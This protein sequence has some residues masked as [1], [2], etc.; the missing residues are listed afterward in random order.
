MCNIIRIITAVLIMVV[1]V[2][3]GMVEYILDT[4]TSSPINLEENLY[5]STT[6]CANTENETNDECHLRRVKKHLSRTT[7]LH[8]A[9][10]YLPFSIKRQAKYITT[11]IAFP[12]LTSRHLSALFCT[13]LI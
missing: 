6:E 13:F 12:Y 3:G 8:I 11:H 2:H 1:S 4:Q 7:H 9:Y 5:L 10:L